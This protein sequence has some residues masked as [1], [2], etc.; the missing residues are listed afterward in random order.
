MKIVIDNRHVDY[1]GGGEHVRM[2]IA[3]FSNF[4]QIFVVQKPEFYHKN[5]FVSTDIYSKPLKYRYNFIPDLFIYI[6]YRGYV[7]PIGRINAQICFYGIEKNT[8]SYQYALCI[9][10]FV[11]NSV[12]QHWPGVIPVVIPPFFDPD[13]YKVG[14]KEKRLINIGNFFIE[15]DGHSK[16][17][18]LLIDW[19]LN[20][21]LPEDGWIFDFYGFNNNEKFFNQIKLKVNHLE[22]V[23]LYPNAN[24]VD[25]LD[26]LSR[27]RFMIHAMGLGRSKAEQTEHFGLVAVEALLSGC[28][29]IVHQSGG[30]PEIQG[31]LTYSSLSQVQSLINSDEMKP[32][33]IRDFGLKYSFENS[34]LTALK[35]FD[36]IKGKLSSDEPYLLVNNIY[37]IVKYFFR[38]K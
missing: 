33:E 37:R 19:F 22:S 27:S 14:R 34:L 35:F 24:R 11:A 2:I 3:L 23:N 1:S 6:D 5:N 7:Q 12:D 29:P 8:S 4:G 15:S 16:N 32:F 13:M 18:H 21:G 17:Q 30:C 36:S 38:K 20:S 28:R 31:T 10:D 25:M 9:N 26:A